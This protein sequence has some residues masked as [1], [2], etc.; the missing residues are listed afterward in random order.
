MW[1]GDVKTL[2][3]EGARQGHEGRPGSLR[4][5]ARPASP[6]PANAGKG[7]R[8]GGPPDAR[9]GLTAAAARK[10]GVQCGPEEVKYSPS[11]GEDGLE[12]L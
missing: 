3:R 6:C 2:R 10:E 4:Q 9:P 12:T 7:R 1:R 5:E 8:Q 11:E